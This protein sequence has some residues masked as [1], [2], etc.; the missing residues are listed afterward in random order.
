MR[1]CF[2][3]QGKEWNDETEKEVKAL[4]SKAIS[5]SPCGSLNRHHEVVI[6]SLGRNLEDRLR[7]REQAQQEASLTN[8]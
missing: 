2:L 1:D 6:D 7:E 8:A 3:Q 4:I 5:K